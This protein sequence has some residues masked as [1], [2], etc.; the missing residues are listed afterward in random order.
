MTKVLVME[1]FA[2]ISGD[3]KALIWIAVI[4]GATA[5]AAIAG[6]FFVHADDAAPMLRAFF[7]NLRV[8]VAVAV[9]RVVRRRG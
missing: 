8:A 4:F 1:I 5:L 3:L 2:V 9:R 7:F 6:M